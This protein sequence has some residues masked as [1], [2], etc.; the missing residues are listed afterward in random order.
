MFCFFRFALCVLVLFVSVFLLY[1]VSRS[2]I[3]I[4]MFTFYVF[5][6]I[7][8]SGRSRAHSRSGTSAWFLDVQ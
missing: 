6:I 7:W 3:S 5:F 4:V 2:S 1:Y 8:F